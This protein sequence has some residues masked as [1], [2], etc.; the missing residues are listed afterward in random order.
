MPKSKNNRK[1]GKNRKH[2]GRNLIVAANKRMKA[3]K[4]TSIDAYKRDLEFLQK[5]AANIRRANSQLAMMLTLIDKEEM[6]AGFLRA[7]GS[8][9][10]W[11]QSC[12]RIDRQSFQVVTSSLMLGLMI[13][14]RL[15]CIEDAQSYRYE[16]QDA[17]FK[18]WIL[19]RTALNGHKLSDND[20]AFIHDALAL[21]Q[22]LMETAYEVDRQAFTDVLIQNDRDYI[23]A[24][25]EVIEPRHKLALG[26]HYET[27]LEWEKKDA[28]KLS[29]L[30]V[31][32]ADLQKYLAKQEQTR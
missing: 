2:A 30:K 1:N 19:Y 23:D 25:P 4:Y 3:G 26:R 18:C 11:T 9:N 17:C 6:I 14:E 7:F 27:I 8:L 31:S 12:G 24:H 32:K 13:L 22:N 28:L 21:A 5:D 10:S 20:I 15:D 16:L 29:E